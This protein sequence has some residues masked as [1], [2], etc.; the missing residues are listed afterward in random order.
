MAGQKPT[1]AVGDPSSRN[2]SRGRSQWDR[3][4]CVKSGS[5]EVPSPHPTG[6][7]YEKYDKLVGNLPIIFSGTC[8]PANSYL[9]AWAEP[10]E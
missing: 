9:S 1:R 7:G 8:P 2:T 5:A 6:F 4:V 10:D 3:G